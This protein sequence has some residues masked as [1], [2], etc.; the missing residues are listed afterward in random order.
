MCVTYPRLH[1]HCADCETHAEWMVEG[2][3]QSLP[4]GLGLGILA[5]S[6][7]RAHLSSSPAPSSAC[8][9]LSL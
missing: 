1:P 5:S 8:S 6:S 3:H 7:R 4:R 2:V 9:S